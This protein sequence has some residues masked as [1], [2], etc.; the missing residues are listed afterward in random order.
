MTYAIKAPARYAQGA[1]ELANLGRS[2][3][4]LGDKFLVICSDNSRGRFGAQVEATIYLSGLGFE[5]GGLAA[6]HAVNDGFAQEPQAHGMYHGE[7]VAFGTLVQ[8]VLEKA[9]QE[10]LEQVLAFLRDTGLP[11]TLAQL[12]VKEIVPETLK[13][14]AEAAVVPTQ[15]TKNLRADI[16]AQEVYDA[17]LEADRIGR[18]YLAR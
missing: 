4:K 14:V 6:A 5:N 16:T 13:K 9:P 17:I 15:S 7:K 3:K 10:E 12:G 8:L 11:L 1:G 18:D 2:A